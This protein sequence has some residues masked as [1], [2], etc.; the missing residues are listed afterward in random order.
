MTKR[1]QKLYRLLTWEDFQRR[2]IWP[3]RSKKRVCSWHQD[4]HSKTKQDCQDGTKVTWSK[5]ISRS[6]GI[7]RVATQRESK[8]AQ[9]IPKWHRVWTWGTSREDQDV[10]KGETRRFGAGTN[11]V[12]QRQTKMAK[13][14][15]R[16]HGVRTS[17][18]LRRPRWLLKDQARLPRWDQSGIE[19]RHGWPPEKTKMA[20]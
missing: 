13:M 19:Y 14:A 6:Q 12:T 7:P 11:M 5:N 2:P 1:I 9:R 10:L 17:R 15:L 18:V 3:Q 8:M 16:W 20:Q 4:G